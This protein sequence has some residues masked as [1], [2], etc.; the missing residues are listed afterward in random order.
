[1]KKLLVFCFLFI[2]FSV[3]AYKDRNLLQKAADIARLERMLVPDQKWVSYP[4]YTDRNGWDLL[5]GENKA[6]C[7]EQGEKYLEYEWKAVKATDYLEYTRTGNRSTMESRY[8]SNLNAIS[9]LFMAEMAEGK[10]RFTDQLVNGIFHTCEMTSW[11]LSAHLVL[12][13]VKSSFPR[14][15]DHVIE[16]V[17]SDVG[18]TFSWIYYFLNKEFDKI[19][20]LISERLRYEIENRIMTPYLNETRFWW[21]ATDVT[22]VNNWNPWCNANVLQCFLLMEK[23][24]D[25]L[26]KGIY[27]TM[28]SVDKFLNYNHDDGACEEGPS[29]WGHAAGKM[30]DYLQILYDA[31]GGQISV[32]SDPMVKNMGEYISRS[33]AGNGWV[34]NFA[35]ASAKG[36]FD[37]RLIYR[38]G[39]SVGSVEMEQFASFLKKEYP[40]NISIARDAYRTLADLAC[41]KEID[42]LQPVHTVTP[43]AWYPETGFCYMSEGGFFFAAKGGYNDESHNHNDVGSFSLYAGNEPVLIDIGVGT[44]TGKTFSSERY[45][46]RTMQSDYH[47]LPRI[48]GFPQSYGKKYKASNAKADRN[49]K[50]FSLDIAKAYPAEAGINRWV[51]SYKLSKNSLL[52]E[53]NFDITDSRT[54]NQLNFITWGKVDISQPGVVSITVKGKTYRLLYDR[55][56]FEPVLEKIQ[57]DDIRLSRVWGNE[58]VRVSLNAKNI[59]NKGIYKI[60][61]KE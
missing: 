39:K 8:N 49:K 35:D 34:V 4:A 38:Y 50:T 31:T 18:A 22:F 41:D 30:Y 33:Y 7:I 12:Q 2:C 29:Y 19:N 9:A 56:T 21:M 28:V 47:N 51:R 60:F 23:D 36:D 20:P 59:S 46:I 6:R 24:R 44:Y 15:G 10:G 55:N 11:S 61:I 5:L 3:Y 1:M 25:R 37:Y 17:S 32:F 57:L 52:I 13:R 53:D 42:L 43:F 58:I 16:L 54:A 27:K 45:T 14:L 40:K 48:N 26:L